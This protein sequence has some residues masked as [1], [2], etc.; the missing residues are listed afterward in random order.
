MK[1]LILALVVAAIALGAYFLG[2]A[3]SRERTTEVESA[4]VAE[5]PG[6][7][8]GHPP[9]GNAA[10]SLPESVAGA[11]VD[12]DAHFTH[13]R[14]GR[15]NVKVILPDGN[16]MWVGTSGGVIRYDLEKDNY[17]LFDTRSGLLAN[18]IFHL[19]KL[20]GRLVAGTYGG[21]LAI[22]NDDGETWKTYNI[23]DGLG[24][25]FIYD[26]LETENGDVWIA[27][28]SGAN[29]VRGGDLDDRSKWDLFTVANTSGGLP[30][31]WVY[32]LR[33]GKDGVV[34]LATEGGLAK[35]DDG[36]WQQW[37]HRDGM[38]APYELVREQ[39]EFST[40]PAQY[41]EHHARQKEEMGLQGVDIAYNPNYIVALMVDRGG[42][43]WCG[44]WGGGLARFDG[45]EWRNF[46]MADGLPGN[47]VFMLHEDDQGTLWVGT[48]NGLARRRSDGFDV[49]T[50]ADGLYS[51]RV[52]A[53]NTADDGSY[54]VGSFG[55]VARIESLR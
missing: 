29:R 39:I 30:N 18:G 7:P 50:T 10:L 14:V 49:F 53:M 12:P 44:T 52:F 13:F 36:N 9:A 19:S 20:Q 47:H 51:N 15:S 28:W 8:A 24:D 35:F 31:D 4:A 33:T 22:M 34:W 1:N 16:L 45:S 55:G 37:D 43:V 23:P 2:V 26:V 3:T 54:W 17:R 48:N 40:D 32:G 25:A 6:L 41:S 11:P 42:I 46:T 38:G 21:G 5:S 27:T